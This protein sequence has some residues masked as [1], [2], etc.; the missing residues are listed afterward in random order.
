MACSFDGAVLY[1]D[2]DLETLTPD[3]AAL[4][5]RFAGLEEVAL[6]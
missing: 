6:F 1:G 3:S 5:D 2:A 4:R